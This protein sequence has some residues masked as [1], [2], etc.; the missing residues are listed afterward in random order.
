M[1]TGQKRFRRPLLAVLTATLVLLG[2]GCQALTTAVPAA[3]PATG[4]AT[5]PVVAGSAAAGPATAAELRGVLLGSEDVPAGFAPVSGTADEDG[6]RAAFQGTGCEELARFLNAEKLPG[7]HADAAVS[8]SSGATGAAAAEQL[9]AMDSPEAAARAVDRYRRGAQK[10]KELTLSVQGARTSTSSVQPISLVEV[11][12]AST[13][14]RM[15]EVDADRSAGQDTIQLVSHSGSVVVA[16][17]LM[18]A[19]PPDAETVAEAAVH[20]VRHLVA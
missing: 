4:G 18:G 17:T 13:A 15:R 19:A 9:Y 20:K 11:G 7:S 3:P 8:L 12:D 1:R 5:T 2:T 6:G 10:C 14:T 16:V